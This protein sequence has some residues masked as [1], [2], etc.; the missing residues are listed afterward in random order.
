MLPAALFALT[1]TQPA[2]RQIPVGGI[3]DPVRAAIAPDGG[4]LANAVFVNSTADDVTRERAI[5]GAAR[6]AY[7]AW[8]T[9]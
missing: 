4:H 3:R 6:F 7:D 5:A 8:T 1:L 9:K 2:P